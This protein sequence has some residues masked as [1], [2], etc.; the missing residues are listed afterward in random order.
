MT[1]QQTPPQTPPPQPLPEN[2][3]IGKTTDGAWV[4]V[5]IQGARGT[6]VH[7]ITP[8]VAEFLGSNLAAMAK[9][10]IIVPR[11]TIFGSNGGG[12]S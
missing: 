6:C 4:V 10:T 12:G 11:G 1:A 7:F 5:T 2:W 3:S 9:S 8:Q